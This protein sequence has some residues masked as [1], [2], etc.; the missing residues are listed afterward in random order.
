[1]FIIFMFMICI[2][3]YIVMTTDPYVSDGF[4]VASYDGDR[5]KSHFFIL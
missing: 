2:N 3:V 4:E 5:G 1:M